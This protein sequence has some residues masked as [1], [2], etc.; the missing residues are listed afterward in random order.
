MAGFCEH[1]QLARVLV[2]VVLGGWLFTVEE[3]VTS[4]G[5]VWA[6]LERAQPT[7]IE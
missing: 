3:R 2:G 7:Y 4:T 1:I 6:G 5:V